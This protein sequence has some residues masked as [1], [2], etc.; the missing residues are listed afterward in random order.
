MRGHHHQDR[1]HLGFACTDG[2]PHLGEPKIALRLIP[3][4][5]RDPVSWISRGILGPDPG[6]VL[7]EPGRGPR[8]AHPFSQHRRRH[9]RVLQQQRTN[10]RFHSL[11]PG[12]L[13]RPDVSWRTVS[14][15]CF[16]NG[17]P[18]DPQPRSYRPH[19]LTLGQMQPPNKRP[20]LHCDHPPNRL[21]RVAHFSTV[22]MAHFSTVTDKHRPDAMANAQSL[23]SVLACHVPFSGSSS[24]M[25]RCAKAGPSTW[26]SKAA[27]TR[28]ASALS[29]F[30]HRAGCPE[31]IALLAEPTQCRSPPRG[32]RRLQEP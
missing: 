32:H 7:P 26:M 15:H 28:C 12:V 9:S 11:D 5:I 21:E 10:C 20:I 16:C 6:H 3:G 27:L 30:R 24:A 2:Y 17:V 4:L 29:S 14:A 19:R 23:D 25:K 18:G 31:I 13:G 1:Q 8:P 22:A